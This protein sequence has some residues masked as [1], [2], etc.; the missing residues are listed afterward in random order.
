M[1]AQACLE[2]RYCLQ[3]RS[4]PSSKSEHAYCQADRWTCACL[5]DSGRTFLFFLWCK[6]QQPLQHSW[7]LAFNYN[8]SMSIGNVKITCLP[9]QS[10]LHVMNPMLIWSKNAG[11]QI[12]LLLR[13][14]CALGFLYG[15]GSDKNLWLKDQS[16]LPPAQRDCRSWQHVL[17][18]FW[19]SAVDYGRRCMFTLTWQPAATSTMLISSR[20]LF[21]SLEPS[22][23]IWVCRI[24]MP[25]EHACHIAWLKFRR[26]CCL[27]QV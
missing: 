25:W 1:I 12:S 16:A 22:C 13:H 23:Q 7:L 27:R 15:E 11:N 10:S 5:W 24:Q 21:L 6:M 17:L 4:S 2:L 19:R 3:C 18:L 26:R 20:I 9:M 8:M 14:H